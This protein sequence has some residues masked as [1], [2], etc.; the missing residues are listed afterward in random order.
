M[1]SVYTFS[2]FLIVE[3][4]VISQWQVKCTKIR[5]DNPSEAPKVQILF[6]AL[7]E[8]VCGKDGRAGETIKNK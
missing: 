5:A 3:S 8:E 7:H 4:L 6:R 1:Y 2:S